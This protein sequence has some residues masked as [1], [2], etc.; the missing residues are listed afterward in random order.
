MAEERRISGVRRIVI[1]GN[2]DDFV[3]E[4]KEAEWE[5]GHKGKSVKEM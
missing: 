4:G 3:A 5:G 2:D 1:K